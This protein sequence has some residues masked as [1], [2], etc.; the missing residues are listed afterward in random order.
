MFLLL[1]AEPVVGFDVLRS[2]WLIVQPRLD[3]LAQL[4]IVIHDQDFAGVRHVSA[5]GAAVLAAVL[6]A[7]S[8]HG[9]ARNRAFEGKRASWIAGV[10]LVPR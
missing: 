7:S 6:A 10:M 1:E 4:G 5:P 3:G 8:R 9:M 2:A